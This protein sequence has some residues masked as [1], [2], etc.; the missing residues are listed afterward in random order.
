MTTDTK[1]SAVAY[2]GAHAL[3]TSFELPGLQ[4]AIAEFA[5]AHG[6]I[7]FTTYVEE[8]RRTTAA[9]GEMISNVWRDGVTTV[10]VPNVVHLAALGNPVELKTYLEHHISGKVLF[11]NPV[12]L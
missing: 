9:F 11:L 6:F 1:P 7:L 4:A 3:A 2:I 10:V 12:P 5:A 8:S